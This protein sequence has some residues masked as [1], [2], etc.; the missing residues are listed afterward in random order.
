MANDAASQML[1]KM[2]DWGVYILDENGV[3][4]KEINIVKW[5]DWFGKS[6][7]RHVAVTAVG[8]HEVCTDFIGINDIMWETIVFPDAD[9]IRRYYTKAEAE[10]GHWDTVEWVID[11]LPDSSL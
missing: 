1:L 5:A 9:E 4:Q 8:D 6:G 3:P 10:A 11:S 7:N 2:L